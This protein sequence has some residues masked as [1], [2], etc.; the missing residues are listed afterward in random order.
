VDQDLEE[1]WR[2]CRNTC[3]RRPRH[4]ASSC[5]SVPYARVLKSRP[6]SVSLRKPSLPRFRSSVPTLP[7]PSTMLPSS[8]L[9]L[10]HQPTRTCSPTVIE[11]WRASGVDGLA[12][13]SRSRS[14]SRLSKQMPYSVGE[15]N[16]Q[17][18]HCITREIDMRQ[19]HSK[20]P[21]IQRPNEC[22][23]CYMRNLGTFLHRGSHLGSSATYD[24][25]VTHYRL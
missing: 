18:V 4:S 7:T 10:P 1:P 14:R 23:F 8:L 20:H 17:E 21:T 12:T 13:P 5:R 25:A 24:W 6:S 2:P 15:R 9:E 19:I 22:R 3:S 11:S 16:L